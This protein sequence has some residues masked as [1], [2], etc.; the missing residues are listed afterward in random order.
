MDI[1]F[2]NWQTKL[3]CFTYISIGQTWTHLQET[4]RP[5]TCQT[6]GDSK[7]RSTRWSCQHFTFVVTLN[8]VSFRWWHSLIAWSNP[9]PFHTYSCL[10]YSNSW[11]LI[12]FLDGVWRHLYEASQQTK[13][14]TEIL[15]H[16]MTK[17]RTWLHRMWRKQGGGLQTGNIIYT[18]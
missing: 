11:R 18:L 10:K 17:W 2:T 3:T 8:S 9:Q 12:N 14:W 6:Y 13:G 16:E 5:S 1:F 7:H 15:E 4:R